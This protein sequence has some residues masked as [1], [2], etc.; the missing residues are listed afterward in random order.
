MS[1]A[2]TLA[3]TDG[4]VVVADGRTTSVPTEKVEDPS[5]PTSG[6][7]AVDATRDGRRCRET[8]CECRIWPLGDRVRSS[9]V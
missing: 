4:V 9:D 1:I 7:H 3:A 2:F 8:R 5:A 6:G